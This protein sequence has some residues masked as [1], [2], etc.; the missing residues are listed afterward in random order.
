[1]G[2]SNYL[3]TSAIAKPGVCTSS[4]RPASPYEGQVIYETDTDKTLVWNG[5]AWVYLSTSTAN[6]VGLELVKTQTIGSAVGSVAVSD[7]FNSS[8]DNYKIT[9]SGGVASTTSNFRLQLGSN[10]ANYRYQYIYGNLATTLSTE[11][12]TNASSFPYCGMNNTTILSCNIELGNPF[13]ATF[14]TMSSYGGLSG[15]YL[16]TQTGIHVDSV[17]FTAFTLLL[18]TG[19]ITGGTIRVYG[20]RNS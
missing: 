17:S 5:S 6:P 12:A 15:N 13:A 20:Y 8:F 11:G 16:G 2:L 18:S 3:P 4:T 1:M 7:A 19:T 9:V 10:T 14:T